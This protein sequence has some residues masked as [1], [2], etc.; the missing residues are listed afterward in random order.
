MTSQWQKIRTPGVDPYE[1][2]LYDIFGDSWVDD[3]NLKGTPER[4]RRMYKNEFFKNVGVEPADKFFSKFPNDCGYDQMILSEKIHFT[5][6]CS[7]HFL[8]FSGYAYIA[9]IPNLWFIGAS[10]M[11]RLVEHYAKRPQLQETLCHQ[12]I[13]A[14]NEHIQ[15]YGCMVLMKAVHS[16]MSC[17]G[18]QQTN[19]N[20]LTTNALKGVFF[21]DKVKSEALQLISLDILK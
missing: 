17:R 2:L 15:P 11:A 21:E 8:P 4:I 6:M 20:N 10:K 13:E 1:D 7:H 19:G 12:V 5:S 14:F 3:P 16:C 9:Y 18:V